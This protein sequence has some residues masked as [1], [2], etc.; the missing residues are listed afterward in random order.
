[1]PLYTP[2]THHTNTHSLTL[3]HHQDP[4]FKVGTDVAKV[5]HGELYRE[6][7]IDVDE[8]ADGGDILYIIEY[9]DEDSE[10]LNAKDCV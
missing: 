10:D 7:I 9:E 3:T 6:W 4:Q 8:D 2:H 5:F 1:M